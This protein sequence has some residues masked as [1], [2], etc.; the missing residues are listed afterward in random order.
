MKSLSQSRI[1]TLFYYIHV[2][3]MYLQ[4]RTASSAPER[5]SPPQPLGHSQLVLFGHSEDNY[6]LYILR[7]LNKR[8]SKCLANFAPAAHIISRFAA[9]RR[10]LYYYFGG[11]PHATGQARRYAAGSCSA[12]P[13]CVHRAQHSP[14]LKAI[15]AHVCYEITLFVTLICRV[16]G[17]L[18]TSNGLRQGG[19]SYQIHLFASLGP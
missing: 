17:T 19:D 2:H 18:K 1:S 10:P 12:D 16:R 11:R 15:S 4:K 5:I 13:A 8:R 6:I 7:K 14:M 3:Y 9:G